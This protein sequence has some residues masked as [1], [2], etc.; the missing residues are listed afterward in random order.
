MKKEPGRAEFECF[1]DCVSPKGVAIRGC[2]KMGKT[3]RFMLACQYMT[4]G[5]AKQRGGG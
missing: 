3:M 1:T 5:A 4:L 2:R